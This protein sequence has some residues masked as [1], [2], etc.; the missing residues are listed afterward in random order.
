MSQ[1]K[2]FWQSAYS[3][4]AVY[5]GWG[6]CHRKPQTTQERRASQGS[7]YWRS[8]RNSRNIVDAYDDLLFCFQKSWKK[9]T[10]N[11]RQW[12]RIYEM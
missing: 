3:V 10:K 9:R 1:K 8:R 12:R 7:G 4:A 6:R 2:K 5:P 11:R